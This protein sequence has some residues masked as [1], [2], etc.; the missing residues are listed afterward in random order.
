MVGRRAAKRPLASALAAAAACVSLYVIAYPFTRAHYPPL[1][2]MPFHATFMSILRHYFDPAYHFREQFSLHFIEV[3]YWTWH[4]LGAL[5]A[6][7]MPI[8][9]ATKASTIFMLLLLPAGLAVLFHGM[10]KSPLLGLFALPFTWNTL[11][12]WGFI[13]FVAAIGL[14]AMVVGFALLVLDRPTKHRKLGLAFSL[15]LVFGTHI[16]RFPFALAAVVGTGLVMYPAT[17][18]WRPLVAPMLPSVAALFAWIVS[19]P[20]EL[21]AREMGPLRLHF[22]RFAEVPGF[23]FGALTGSEEPRLAEQTYRLILGAAAACILFF[24]IERRYRAWSPREARWAA[25]ITIVP[26]CVAGVFLAMYL[27]LPMQIGIWWY[28]YPREIVSALFIALAALPDLPRAS[29][30]RVPILGA[31]AYGACAQASLVAESF[32][33]FDASAGDFRRVTERIPPAPKLGYMVWDRDH[34]R[35]LSHPFLHMPAWV[36]AE[37]GGW[38]SFHFIA[39]NAAP[40]RYRKGSPAVPPETPIRFEWTPERFDLRTRG[41]FFDWFLVRRPG[42]PDPRFLREPSLRLVDHQGAWWLYRRAP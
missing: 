21:T 12:H 6:L 39:W 11:T 4:G 31:V 7:V 20:K 17:R 26:L 22:E 32:A 34:P 19:R 1:T 36:Q 8:V 2:D 28:V 10:K 42:G 30:L 15:L 18:R 29:I 23:L 3:P 41:Q 14:F 27:A 24:F 16:F 40:I 5:L 13:S 33:A 35:F 25:G 37:K 38:L 9:W